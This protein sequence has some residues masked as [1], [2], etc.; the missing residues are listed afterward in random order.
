MQ[1]S[2]TTGAPIVLATNCVYQ[3]DAKPTIVNLVLSA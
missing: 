3:F 1:S 2:K